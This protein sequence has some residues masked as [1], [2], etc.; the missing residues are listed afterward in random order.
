MF[1]TVRIDSNGDHVHNIERYLKSKRNL[2]KKLL[3]HHPLLCCLSQCSVGNKYK[4]ILLENSSTQLLFV[5][6]I[7]CLNLLKVTVASTLTQVAV[8]KCKHL[9]SLLTQG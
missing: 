4:P 1:S 6:K 5:A 2:L 7:I 3:R 8:C 9:T